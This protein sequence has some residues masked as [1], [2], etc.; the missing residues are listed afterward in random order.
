MGSMSEFFGASKIAYTGE[1]FLA[2]F[3]GDPGKVQQFL[4]RFA[5]V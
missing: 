5:G 1:L 3:Q 2:V 4:I